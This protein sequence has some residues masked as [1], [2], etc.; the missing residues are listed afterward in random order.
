[1]TSFLTAFHEYWK[2]DRFRNPRAWPPTS[3]CSNVGAELSNHDTFVYLLQS[4]RFHDDG[5]A[6]DGDAPI[7]GVGHRVSSGESLARGRLETYEREFREAK[8]LLLDEAFHQ[9]AWLFA[10]LR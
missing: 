2:T 5:D 10:A 9:E 6:D 4:V 3:C 7:S 1:M 8:E